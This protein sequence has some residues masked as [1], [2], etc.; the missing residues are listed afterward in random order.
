MEVGFV[1]HLLVHD[2][3]AYLARIIDAPA[4][5]SKD[6]RRLLNLRS[7]P[8]CTSHGLSRCEFEDAYYRH[9]RDAFEWQ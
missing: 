5:I 4:D 9:D 6:L 1:G 2:P 3:S 7:L 8:T